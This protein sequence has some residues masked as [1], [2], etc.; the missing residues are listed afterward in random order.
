MTRACKWGCRPTLKSKGRRNCRRAISGDRPGPVRDPCCK[1]D[2]A[3]SRYRPRRR[4]RLRSSPLEMRRLAF[5]KLAAAEFADEFSVT[6][7]NF[8]ANGDDVRPSLNLESF[9][10]IVIEVHLMRLRGNFSAK[11]RIVNNKIGVTR[12][13]DG[14]LSRK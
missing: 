10:R 9:K 1:D 6:R 3:R 8:P 2:C 12:D 4:A 7:G 13:F 11:V 5:Q 14:A